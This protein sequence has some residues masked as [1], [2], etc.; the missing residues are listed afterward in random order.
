LADRF[1]EKLMIIIRGE[2]KEDYPAVRKVNE[3]AFAGTGEADLVDALRSSVHP[4]ISLVAVSDGRL[5]GHIFFSPVSIVSE[6]ATFSALALGPMAVLPEC[7]N[8]GIGSQLARRGLEECRSLG[9][10]IVVVVGHSRFYPR[11]GF[12]PASERG[13]EC[14]YPVPDDIFMVAE[15]REGALAQVGGL[16]KYHAEFDKV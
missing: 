13:L 5:V 12:M 11:F 16:I 2:T 7:Q 3:L 4:Y 14:E 6:V 1:S 10:D 9:H 8:Q 15:L